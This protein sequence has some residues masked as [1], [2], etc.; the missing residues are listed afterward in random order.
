MPPAGTIG[1]QELGLLRWMGEREAATVA[2]V[3]EGYGT[4]RGL[5]RSTVLT[6]MERLRR[7][8]YLTRRR[9]DG[10]FRYRAAVGPQDAL[11][12]AVSAFVER[13]LGG[14]VSPLVAYLDDTADVTPEDLAEL[15]G[16]VS[17]L[18]TRSGGS[19]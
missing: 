1:D 9:V 2:E 15:E 13:T 14:S 10:V 7:K 18:Q 16:L 17:R 4:L 19:S 11:K 5:A 8:G 3:V 6:M 12:R